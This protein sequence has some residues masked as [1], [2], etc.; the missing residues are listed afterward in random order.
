VCSFILRNIYFAKF[1]SLVSYG[2]IFW[3]GEGE[4]N[5]VLKIQK[6]ILCLMRGVSSR[7][8]CRPTFRELRILTVTSLYVF[9]IL[10][11][12]SEI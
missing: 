5:K 8:S 10:C 2:L 12:L 1:Q 4:S 6:R 3:G 7:T 9:E 11:F